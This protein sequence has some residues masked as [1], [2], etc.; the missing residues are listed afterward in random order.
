VEDKV[1]LK[2]VSGFV[3]PGQ[4]LAIVGSTG[5]GKT[6]LLDLLAGKVRNGNIIGNSTSSPLIN[7]LSSNQWS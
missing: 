6:T 2:G 1:I 4:L 3:K 7:R 5:A